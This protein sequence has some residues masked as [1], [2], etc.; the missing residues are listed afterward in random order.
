MPLCP[1]DF[2]ERYS[3][4]H[5]DVARRVERTV[6]GHEVGLNG[7]TMYAQAEN[8][9]EIL[10]VSRGRRLLDLG[11]GYGWPG[12]HIAQRDG[13]DLV[14]TDVP[15]DALRNAQA[16]INEVGIPGRSVVVAADGGRL[17]FRSASFDAIVHA[18]VFC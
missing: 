5:G 9:R 6:L 15:L 16:Q 13:G 10:Q 14:A 11:C 2:E 7:Y 12:V 1:D 8:L 3:R 4:P 18:D 17:S